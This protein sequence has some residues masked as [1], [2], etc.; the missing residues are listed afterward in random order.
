MPAPACGRFAP[1][2]NL[3]LVHPA[4]GALFQSTP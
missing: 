3:F 1:D 2:P 4:D